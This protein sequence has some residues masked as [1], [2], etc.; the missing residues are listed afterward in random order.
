MLSTAVAILN[1]NG[2]GFLQQ[3]LPTVVTR[4]AQAKVYVIDNGSTDASLAW[5]QSCSLPITVIGLDQNYGFCQGYN[6]GIRQISEEIVVLLNS[7]V[8]PAEDW[9][10]HLLPA[11]ANPKVA[12]AQPKILDYKIKLATGR[13]VFEYAGASG[14]FIDSIGLPYCRGRMIDTCETDTGQYDTAISID[15][16]TGAALAVRR[17]LF[18]SAGGL[19]PYF[20]AHMEEIDLCWRLR[21][22]GHTII[23]QP[24]SAVY[25]VG[26]GTLSKQNPKKTYLNHR[27][28]LVLLAKNLRPLPAAWRIP[29]RMVLDFPIALTYLFQLGPQHFWAVAEAHFHFYGYLFHGSRHQAQ[30]APKAPTIA[31]SKSLLASYF[32][33]GKRK[34]SDL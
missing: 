32:L 2:L 4:S 24:L 13:N 31:N 3:F 7:D 27:N 16:A 26:G 23:C 30:V 8:E 10:L 25:H 29:L 18:E 20:F 12:A 14:G 33:F 17:D 22:M 15:W 5:L 6:L 11:F 21:R 34:F 1:F 28:S 19:D 9:L